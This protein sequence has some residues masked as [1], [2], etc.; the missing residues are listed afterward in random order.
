MT[1]RSVAGIAEPAAAPVEMAAAVGVFTVILVLTADFIYAR[2]T[3]RLR[4][5]ADSA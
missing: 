5:R 3:R 1:R 4:R 2:R